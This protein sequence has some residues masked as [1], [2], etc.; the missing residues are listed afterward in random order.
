MKMISTNIWSA[1]GT[2]QLSAINNPVRLFNTFPN[3]KGPRQARLGFL[4]SVTRTQMNRTSSFG[5]SDDL[6]TQ[7]RG[8]ATAAGLGR[9]HDRNTCGPKQIPSRPCYLEYTSTGW[10]DPLRFLTAIAL[11]K[12]KT[13]NTILPGKTRIEI[14]APSMFL[15]LSEIR[16]NL[17]RFRAIDIRTDID[18]SGMGSLVFAQFKERLVDPIKPDRAFTSTQS[19]NGRT[20]VI[21]LN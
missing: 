4:R 6:N 2:T 20:S 3:L 5:T 21:R 18:D 17:D 1:D 16:R 13:G 9:P 10:A 19:T 7:S 14:A 12:G 8:R 11:M 15:G